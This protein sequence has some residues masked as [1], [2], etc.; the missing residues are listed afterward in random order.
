MLFRSDEA[1]VMMIPVLLTGTQKHREIKTLVQEQM[2]RTG[3]TRDSTSG[4]LAPEPV[5]STLH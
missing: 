2:T 4:N 3:Q 5:L 1:D